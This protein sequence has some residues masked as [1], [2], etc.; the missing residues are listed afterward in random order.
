MKKQLQLL[1]LC[2]LVSASVA[3]AQALRP[4]ILHKIDRTR[5]SV[6]I[7]LVGQN[8]I[9]F[10]EKSA[11]TTKRV[12]SRAIVWKIVYTNGTT[13]VITPIPDAAPTPALVL[14]EIILRDST[15]RSG[16]IL[17]RTSDSLYYAVPNSGTA[18]S[19]AVLLS[20]VDRLKYADGR[21]EVIAPG[22]RCRSSPGTR[23]HQ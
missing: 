6:K 7:Q 8:S 20:E 4:A 5:L 19:T 1:L 16:S 17:R 23:T 2:L 14:D 11:P 13:Q 18:A 9:V 22:T 21:Q 15:R 12:L 10:F 3:T